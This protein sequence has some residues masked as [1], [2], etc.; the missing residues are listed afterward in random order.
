MG[1]LTSLS[2]QHHTQLKPHTHDRFPLQNP[3]RKMLA[4]HYCWEIRLCVCFSWI[5]MRKKENMLS[6]FS[7]GVSIS[8]SCFSSGW[9]TT[10]NTFVCLLRDPRVLRI[11]YETGA[12][13]RKVAFVMEIAHSLR[14]NRLKSTNRLSPNFYLT[15]SNMRLVKAGPRVAPVDQ[16]SPL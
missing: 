12:H 7:S 5:S 3:S 6:F 11:K 13:L 15:R 2:I 1:T 10:R 8:S 14:C 4:E 9:F 16:N